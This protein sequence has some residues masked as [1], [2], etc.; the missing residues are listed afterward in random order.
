MSGF[1]STG[2]SPEDQPGLTD[3]YFR[4]TRR[5]VQAKGDCDVEYAVF[6]RRP[7]TYAGQLAV[8]WLKAMAALCIETGVFSD[9]EWRA[10]QQQVRLQ[11]KAAQKRMSY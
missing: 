4:N 5:I 7:V 8:D 3:T 6:M 2:P 9:H 11:N 1:D 10:K